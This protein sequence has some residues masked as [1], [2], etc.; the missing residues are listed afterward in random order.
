MASPLYDVSS[1]TASISGSSLSGTWQSSVMG[2]GSVT[3]NR[4]SES[5]YA[6]FKGYRNLLVNDSQEP[7][8]LLL[9]F[10]NNG[11]AT[12]YDQWGGLKGNGF[13]AA[14]GIF[15]VAVTDTVS[16][17][18]KISGGMLTDSFW[19]NYGSGSSEWPTV[20][21]KKCTIIPK[22]IEM[23]KT[24]FPRAGEEISFYLDVI[25]DCGDTTAYYKFFYCPDYGAENFNP[26]LWVTMRAFSADRTL[27]YTFNDPGFYIV[28][29]W[30]SPF[31]DQPSPITQGGFTIKVT[32]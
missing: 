6:G 26:D 10:D 13:I 28:V 3:G 30:T 2:T 12:L 14:D 8:M 1:M 32:N 7:F 22:Y 25:S 4:Q 17:I 27:K 19:S 20:T 5:V 31:P 29:A 9:K 23:D 24:T 21:E 11:T 16:L 18:G 15:A